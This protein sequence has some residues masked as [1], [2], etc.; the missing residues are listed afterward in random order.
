MST[1]KY[2]GSIQLECDHPN[3]NKTFD[4]YDKDDFFVMMKDAKKAGWLT[5][6]RNGAWRN[7]CEW[8]HANPD[9]VR[10][11]PG[12]ECIHDFRPDGSCHWCDERND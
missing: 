10:R 7:F 9:A 8:F 4:V 1:I 3:C 5:F 12:M 2:M 11:L 6:K